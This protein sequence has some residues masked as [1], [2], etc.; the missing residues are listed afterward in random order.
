MDQTTHSYCFDMQA[1]VCSG[2]MALRSA[3][4]PTRELVAGI[5]MGLLTEGGGA[6][7]PGANLVLAVGVWLWHVKDWP[8]DAQVGHVR[9]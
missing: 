5:S 8:A 6:L 7:G 4:V 2:A 3:G 1:A 9:K